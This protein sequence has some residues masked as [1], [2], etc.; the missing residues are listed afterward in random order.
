VRTPSIRILALAAAAVL[1]V[2]G[3]PARG[4]GDGARRR[5]DPVGPPYQRLIERVARHHG[6]DPDLLAALVEVES[7]RDAAA[8][9]AKGAVGLA[10]MLPETARRFG[11]RDLA[12]PEENLEGAARY[13]RFLL[14]RFRGDLR[15]VLAAWNAGEGAV[16]RYGGVP[17]YPETVAFVRKVLSR[18]RDLRG[19]VE[20]PP[21]AGAVRVERDPAGGI[22]VT[23][24]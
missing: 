12:D 1:C 21:G 8:R 24:R 6:L 3:P 22:V 23:N 16:E 15:L 20:A 11:A 19:P 4:A 14:R 10:Q 13:L 9:S 7:G 17:P 18:Y 5:G 2:A